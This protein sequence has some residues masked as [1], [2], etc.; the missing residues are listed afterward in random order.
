[1][2]CIV[3]VVQDG[4]VWVGGDSASVG[5]YEMSVSAVPKVWVKDGFAYGCT[6]SWRMNQLLRYS[7]HPP[8]PRE[9][10]D[11]MGYMCTDFIDAVRNCFRV[12]G[13]LSKEKEAES[14]GTF[15]V[16]YKGRL[17]R[18]D[19]DYQVG[20]AMCGYDACGCGESHARGS[21]YTTNV[22]MVPGIHDPASPT[23]PAP[24]LIA[25]EQRLYI[26]LNAAEQHSAG[27]RGPHFVVSV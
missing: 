24:Q 17:F 5:G 4:R 23:L 13:F 2:T 18:V 9:E 7:F 19:S 14:G 21:L 12:G 20:E 10:A 8:K 15:L 26:A 27:V 11:L 6:T 22:V 16:G 25:P 3:G 1:M